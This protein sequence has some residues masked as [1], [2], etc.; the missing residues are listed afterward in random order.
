MIAIV[1]RSIRTHDVVLKLSD[2]TEIILRSD[3]PVPMLTNEE[4]AAMEVEVLNLHNTLL[5]NMSKLIESDSY[6]QLTKD[7]NLFIIL[8]NKRFSLMYPKGDFLRYSPL[9][10]LDWLSEG[11][12]VEVMVEEEKLARFVYKK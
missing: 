5:A 7:D 9:F 10:Y 1:D 3:C 12:M 2:D 6:I 11:M 4:Q 8:D